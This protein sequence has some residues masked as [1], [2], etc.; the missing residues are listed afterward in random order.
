MWTK[1]KGICIFLLFS[2]LLVF[3]LSNTEL[4]IY[5]DFNKPQGISEEYS[6]SY[7]S[8]DPIRINSDED[9]ET[10]AWPGSGTKEDPYVIENLNITAAKTC[11][12]I[13]DATVY[14]V[15][16]SCFIFAFEDNCGM[17]IRLSTHARVESCV[18]RSEGEGIVLFNSPNVEIFNSTLT[19]C[20]NGGLVSGISINITL[21]ECNFSGCDVVIWGDNYEDWVHNMTNNYVNGL[22]LGYFHLLNDTYLDGRQFGEVILVDCHEISLSNGSFYNIS[23]AIQ[24]AFCDNCEVEGNTI[25]VSTGNAIVLYSVDSCIF[26][27]NTIRC[28]DSIAIEFENINNTIIS[29]NDVYACSSGIDGREA[30]NCTFSNNNIHNNSR[31]GINMNR[32]SGCV[33]SNNIINS[34]GMDGI[35]LMLVNDSFFLNNLISNCVDGIGMFLVRRSVIAN[36]TI[37]NGADGIFISTGFDVI[38]FNNLIRYTT[39]GIIATECTNCTINSNAITRTYSDGIELHLCHNC[40]VLNNSVTSCQGDGIILRFADNCILSLNTVTGNTHSGIAI[41]DN[42]HNSIVTYNNIM[43]NKMYGIC[44]DNSGNCNIFGNLIGWNSDSNAQDDGFQNQWDDGLNLGNIWSDYEGNGS[45]VVP[46]SAGSVDRFPSILNISTTP[47]SYN[48]M[49]I[50]SLILSLTIVIVGVIIMTIL[51]KRK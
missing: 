3:Q 21:V 25:I 48:P 34:T 9:F 38:F 41:L 7:I 6:K 11:I 32:I 51:I 35:S 12:W 29:N 18:I 50:I 4:V 33:I 22:P 36:N 46:G 16:R 37:L 10:Q 24:M 43:E 30:I 45:Y 13:M 23:A 20:P 44:V 40:L 39:S 49:P 8:H 15:I 14:F 47:T 27:N 2:S 26:E 19:D 31:D 42:S 1:G 17:N 5:S 28:G